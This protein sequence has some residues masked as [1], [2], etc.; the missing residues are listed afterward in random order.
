MNLNKKICYWLGFLFIT[1]TVSFYFCEKTYQTISQVLMA[2]LTGSFI[3]IIISI[4]NYWHEK[5]KF[6]NNLFHHSVSIYSY[7]ENIKQLIL[8]LNEI[9]N[10]KYTSDLLIDS[11]NLLKSSIHNIN[12]RDYSPFNKFSKEFDTI[13]LVK[14]LCKTFKQNIILPTQSIKVLSIELSLKERKN[15]LENEIKDLQKQIAEAMST[16]H[17][18]TELLQADYYKNI[19]YLYR[20][21][22]EWEVITKNIPVVISNCIKEYIR[23]K[24]SINRPK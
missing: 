24:N 14:A 5:E 6:F 2:I 7:L 19:Q 3:S 11:S 1:S 16:L 12:F 20:T 13:Q 17:T 23:I 8:N 10:L 18:S 15:V 21:T 4:I 22:N 9:S